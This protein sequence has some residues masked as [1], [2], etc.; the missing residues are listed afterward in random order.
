MGVFGGT[1]TRRALLQRLRAGLENL[2][3]AGCP[4]VLLDGSF[5]TDKPNPA[6]VDGCWH[7][8]PDMKED[9]LEEA[10]WLEDWVLDRR[11]LILRFGMDFFIADA[12]ENA[13][14]K[15]FAEFFLTDRDGNPKGIVRLDLKRL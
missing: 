4:W 14:G 6:D 2:H 1:P 9:V 11:N 7:Y 15:P 13:S 5:T 8:V 3:N 10:F 12:L